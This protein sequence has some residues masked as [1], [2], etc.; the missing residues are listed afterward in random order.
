MDSKHSSQ[1]P[2][3]SFASQRAIYLV[4]S[5]FDSAHHS[6]FMLKLFSV[7]FWQIKT[8]NL[9]HIWPIKMLR[10]IVVI[11]ITTLFPTFLELC[12][13]PLNV[14]GPHKFLYI[15]FALTPRLQS[16]S[17]NS[18]PIQLLA[19]RGDPPPPPACASATNSFYFSLFRSCFDAIAA[20]TLGHKFLFPSYPFVCHPC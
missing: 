18:G 19:Q 7:V 5:S 14:C 12:L 20:P 4:S 9:D 15:V 10:I 13:K 8:D 11:T 3:G 17:V 1:L 16:C 6:A 2:W